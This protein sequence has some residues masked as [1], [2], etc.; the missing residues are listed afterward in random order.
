[1][2]AILIPAYN[3]AESL[4][5]VLEGCQN[6]AFETPI[7]VVDNG[8]SDDTALVA[9]SCGAIVLH[10]PTGYA[11]ALKHGYHWAMENGVKALVQLDADGQ[12]PPH[13]IPALLSASKPVIGSLALD[14]DWAVLAFWNGV[15]LRLLWDRISVVNCAHK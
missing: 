1:M 9:K 14:K 6:W 10:C 12:H 13:S 5:R 2:H 4:P 8:S 11:D 15:W 7:I 3:E